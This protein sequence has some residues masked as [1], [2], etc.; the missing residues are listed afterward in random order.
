MHT[1]L[2]TFHLDAEKNKAPIEAV[3]KK[4]FHPKTASVYQVT[5]YA[6]DAERGLWLVLYQRLGD[7]TTF[8]HTVRDWNR[9]GRF[10]EIKNWKNM[11]DED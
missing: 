8:A 11:E 10:V 2:K 6:F 5:G 4:Y 1:P 9:E 3:E 7:P